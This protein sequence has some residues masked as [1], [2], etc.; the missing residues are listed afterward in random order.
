M[1]RTFRS[2]GA[3][4]ATM[5]AYDMLR[6]APF[7]LGWQTHFL[8]LVHTP[9]K[10]VERSHRRRGDAPAPQNAAYGDYPDNLTFGDFRVSYQEDVSEL[11]AD[12]AFMNAGTTRTPPRNPQA[13]E[14]IVGFGS[15]PLVAYEGTGAYFLDKV[16]TG[17]WRLEVYPDE[18][19]VKDP[20]EQPQAD[21]V[22]SRLLYRTWPMVIHLPDLGNEFFVTPVNVPADQ[23]GHRTGRGAPCR[24]CPVIRGAGCLASHRQRA[25]RSLDPAVAHRACGFRRV[26]HQ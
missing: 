15:S 12:D 24:K 9:K 26:S 14:R 25:D 11:N 4:S 1:A 23:I 5:F 13:L 3:Q 8:N 22:V 21:K 19:L 20:F 10:A 17:V 7:N 2:V 6:T 16:R 18:I